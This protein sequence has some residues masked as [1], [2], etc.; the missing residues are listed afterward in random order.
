MATAEDRLFESFEESSLTTP[1]GLADV[2]ADCVALV[3][4]KIFSSSITS[5]GRQ[6]T[7]EA[8]DVRYHVP[9]ACH[10]IPT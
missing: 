6:I 3:A 5:A 1:A 9:I 2:D 7:C 4:A 10:I 8:L